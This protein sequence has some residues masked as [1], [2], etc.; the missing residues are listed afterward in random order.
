MIKQARKSDL[1]SSGG[2]FRGICHSSRA[3][4]TIL[5][6]SPLLQGGCNITCLLS[7]YY[8][9]TLKTTTTRDKKSDKHSGRQKSRRSAQVFDHSYFSPPHLALRRFLFLRP[10]LSSFYATVL[11]FSATPTTDKTPSR[12]NTAASKHS[13]IF[14]K[15]S[16]PPAGDGTTL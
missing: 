12:T 3:T 7:L 2:N 4:K 9:Q 6:L 16:V 5:L 8:V 13:K 11:F 15:R 10:A 14:G 1:Q